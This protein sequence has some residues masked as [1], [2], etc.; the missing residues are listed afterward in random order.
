MKHLV[1]FNE[2]IES[3]E[4]SDID[5]EYFNN[6][7]VDFIDKGALSGYVEYDDYEHSSNPLVPYEPAYWE[8]YMHYDLSNEGKV[9]DFIKSTEEMLEIYKDIENSI[10]KVKI[11]YPKVKPY[12]VYELNGD[13]GCYITVIINKE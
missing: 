11:K 3:K 2:S 13:S 8:I 12:L 5:I 10:L 1:K 9:E 7:F 6:C 4:W